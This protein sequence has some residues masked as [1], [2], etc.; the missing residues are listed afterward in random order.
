[1]ATLALACPMV[2][3]SLPPICCICANGCS[4]L[5]LSLAIRV[6]RFFWHALLARAQR[7]VFL[8]LALDVFTV[9][10]KNTTALN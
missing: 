5:A 2:W 3:M 7:L 1:M 8:P 10:Q 9:A 4:T 6:V